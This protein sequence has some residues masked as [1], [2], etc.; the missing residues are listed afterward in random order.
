MTYARAGVD[1]SQV[2]KSHEALARTLESTF[3]TRKGKVGHPIFPIGHYAGLV[4]LNDGRILRLQTDNV[5]TNAVSAWLMR[6]YHY[7]GIDCVRDV[8]QARIGKGMHTLDLVHA[9][10]TAR[11]DT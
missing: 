8:L 7:T 1:V 4:D 2:R 11:K 3:K 10:L 5:G 6:K 9:L